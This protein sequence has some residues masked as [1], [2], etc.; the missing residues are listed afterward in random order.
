MNRCSKILFVYS[1]LLC[2]TTNC[3]TTCCINITVA[4]LNEYSQKVDFPTQINRTAGIIDK[5][6]YKSR[7]ILEGLANVNFL[8]HNMDY[9][10]CS[11]LNWGALTAK[12]F[13]FNRIHAIIGPGNHTDIPCCF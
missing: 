10:S 7:E 12:M 9:P 8:I 3:V 4:V 2:V 11:S 13:Y 6:L 1:I 5:A